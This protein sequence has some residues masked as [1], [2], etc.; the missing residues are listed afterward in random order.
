MNCYCETNEG[1]QA[2]S[3]ADKNVKRFYKERLGIYEDQRKQICYIN[4]SSVYAVWYIFVPASA[5]ELEG[6]S[7]IAGMAVTLLQMLLM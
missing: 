2:Y 7:A 3:L 5:G 4:I 1:V 6:E